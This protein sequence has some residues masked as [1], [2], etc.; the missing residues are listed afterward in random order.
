MIEWI[1]SIFRWFCEEP[2]NQSNRS[3]ED[4]SSQRMVQQGSDV[5]G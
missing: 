3:N 2:M 4:S 5:G 1:I